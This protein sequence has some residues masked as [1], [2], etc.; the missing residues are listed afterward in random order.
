M[1]R[2]FPSPGVALAAL[3]LAAV[4]VAAAASPETLGRQPAAPTE[5]QADLRAL[6][7]AVGSLQRRVDDQSALI[8]ALVSSAV[9]VE[10]ERERASALP[11]AA[12][13]EPPS[14]SGRRRGLGHARGLQ[15]YGNGISLGGVTLGFANSSFSGSPRLLKTGGKK[16]I[17]TTQ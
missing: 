17:C 6:L 14:A 2:A 4:S 3:L 5:L 15:A 10:R 13:W 11:S 12:A 1:S 7:S 16:I 8:Q 9:A